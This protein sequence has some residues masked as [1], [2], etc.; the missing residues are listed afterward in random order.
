MSL[1]AAESVNTTEAADFVATVKALQKALDRPLTDFIHYLTWITANDNKV[2]PICDYLY[3]KQ[4]TIDNKK[5]FY[6]PHLKKHLLGPP[7]HPNCRCYLLDEIILRQKGKGKAPE[8]KKPKTPFIDIDAQIR[9]LKKT[10][11]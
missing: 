1:S 4:I 2:C 3:K 5:G 9:A 6:S 10:L 8:P 7:A 11:K